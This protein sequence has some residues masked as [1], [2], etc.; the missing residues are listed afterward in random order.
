MPSEYET[1][2][3]ALLQSPQGM[4]VLKNF[5]KIQDLADKPESRQIIRLLSGKGGDTLKKAAAAAAEG[6]KD[7]AVRLISGLLSTPEGAQL[8]KAITDIM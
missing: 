6:D 1:L 7:M 8:V 5:H 4:A 2:A 3:R